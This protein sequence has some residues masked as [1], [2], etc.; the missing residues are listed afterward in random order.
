MRLFLQTFTSL[1]L[2]GAAGI[3]TAAPNVAATIAACESHAYSIIGLQT[4]N[5]AAIEYLENKRELVRVCAVKA[6]LRFKSQAWSMYAMDLAENVHKQHGTWR[7][8][9]DPNHERNRATANLQINRLMLI[10]MMSEN[11]WE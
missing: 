2:L 4:N 1:L 9:G 10:E 3:T 7:N 8:S 6:G 11:W 5:R